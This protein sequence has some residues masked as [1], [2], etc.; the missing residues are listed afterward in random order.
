M[1]ASLLIIGAGDVG[2]KIAA[3]LLARGGLACLTLAD[4]AP[5][6]DKIAHLVTGGCKAEARALDGTD[7]KAVAA[8]LDQVRPDVIVQAASL[9]SPWAIIGRDHPVA[10]SLSAGGIALQ[11]PCQLPVL[12]TV[13]TCLREC[14]R[15]VP[16]ANISVPD[17]AHPILATQ[18]LAPTVGLGN[19][20]I[21]HLR[22]L[23]ALRARGKPVPLLR[24]VG[25]HHHVYGVMQARPPADP[26]RAARV[27]LGEEGR[28]DDGLA[29]AGE[30]V[31]P[32]PVYNEITAAAA[33]PVVAALLRG[34]APLRF[35]APAP[36][37]LPG[38]YP[39][40]LDGGRVALD[41]P[42]GVDLDEA[43]AFNRTMGEAD[44]LAGI[45]AD[46]TVHFTA[47]AQAAVAELDPVLAEPLRLADLPIRARRLQ[48][49]VRTIR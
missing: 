6:S 1:A 36:D 5:R 30:A 18:G 45:E 41:L 11:L 2:L 49:L 29:Y 9:I 38:G 17:L 33:V 12:M 16:V 8:L 10:R 23:A 4:A 22:A 28:R 26:S 32:G 21:L 39:V 14:G 43:I 40:C 7:P 31:T 34:A 35:S 48:K 3:G 44:G 20:S 15:E 27:Y 46:G 25:H 19:V 13:M 42:P 37:G 47:A 24:I